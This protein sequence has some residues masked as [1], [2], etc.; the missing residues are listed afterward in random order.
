MP[1]W[2]MGES[3]WGR[4]EFRVKKVPN[5]VAKINGKT[6]G[7]ITKA[8]LL[9]QIGVAA[10]MENFDFDLKFT[11]TEFTVSTTVQGFL[12]EAT[13]K[14]YKFTKD[15]KA[16]IRNLSRGQ[17][18]YIQDIKAVGPDGSTRDLSTIALLLN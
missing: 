17:R 15:Q 11:V 13:S 9:A 2:V 1:I 12:Q 3:R 4:R 14:S 8:V 5:P 7:A 18:V 16:I 6:G 10:E